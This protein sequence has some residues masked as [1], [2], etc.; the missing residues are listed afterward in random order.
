MPTF[1]ETSV[2][3]SGPPS[4]PFRA[5]VFRGLG[6]LLPPLLTVVLIFA[7]LGMLREYVF[8]PVENAANWVIASWLA[9]SMVP[10]DEAE[11]S[12]PD[13]KP[14]GDRNYKRASDGNY[15]PEHIYATVQPH[16][17]QVAESLTSW[18]LYQKY[19]E[20]V[21]LRPHLVIP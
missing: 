7:L 3:P 19:V 11:E 1:P 15:V 5:A 20:L 13:W 6:G 18:Q 17:T 16:E 9:Q 14:I 12:P 21:I 10:E 2:G 8:L 4:Q